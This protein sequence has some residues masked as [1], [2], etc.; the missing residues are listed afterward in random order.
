MVPERHFTPQKDLLVIAVVF[1]YN[2]GV[3]IYYVY[4]I[5]YS[6]ILSSSLRYRI[7]DCPSPLLVERNASNLTTK[8]YI[9][10]KMAFFTPPA[11]TTSVF[12]PHSIVQLSAFTS[13]F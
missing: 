4:M 6:S 12:I 11:A 10:K 2:G 3:T 5:L 8:F 1:G 9:F 7:A 13:C